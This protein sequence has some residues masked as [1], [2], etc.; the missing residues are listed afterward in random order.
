MMRTR[1]IL[2]LILCLAVPIPAALA[3]QPDETLSDPALESRA[4]TL[5]QM[6]RCPVCQ[7]ESIDESNAGVARDLR[8][9][10]RDRLRAGD[11]DAQVLAYITARYGEY[12]LFSPA[13]RGVNL[14][15]Y[16]TGPAALLIA[17]G[18][19][20]IWRRR[21]RDMPLDRLTADEEARLREVLKDKV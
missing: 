4:R 9:L 6:L 2:A 11:T 20:L 13:P 5:S 1:G 19:V 15:L 7:G 21:A 18:G 3:L 10:V 8:L 16:G 12:V 14:I 17:L